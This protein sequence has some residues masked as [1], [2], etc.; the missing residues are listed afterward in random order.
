M[1]IKIVKICI[2]PTMF[3]KYKG[4]Y[5][6]SF[7]FNEAKEL[8]K[9]GFEIHVVTPHNSGI[10]FEEIMEGVH[11]HRFKWLEPQEFKALLH[12]KGIKDNLRLLTYLISL[13]FNLIWIVKKYDVDI[14]HAHSV[15]PT[16]LV[17][18]IVAKIV[19]KPVFITA[20]GMDITN[21][22]NHYFFKKLLVFSLIN[23]NKAI[24]VS[25]YLAKIIR[26][27]GTN[28]KNIAILRNAVNINIF[29]PLKNKSLRKYYKIKD[30]D[31]LILF[32]GY[33][34]S[35]KGIFEL[36]NAF[37]EI[38]KYNKNLKLMI[39]G[40]G[41]KENDLKILTK[42][43]VIEKFVLFTGKISAAEIHKYFQSADIF[44]LPSYTDAGGPPLVVIEAMASGLPVIG[45]NVGGIPE[46]IKDGINGFI[47]PP[48]NVDELTKKLDI[49]VDNKELRQK[50]GI[51][52][53]ETV[54]DEFNIDKKIDELVKLYHNE[55]N[56]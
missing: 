7:V 23:C 40:T 36:V 38:V 14:I 32:V 43:L 48:K 28:P 50:F 24:A 2:V 42:K 12:F 35:F 27:L 53:L 13:F 54:D 44:V 25:E 46:G 55:L 5:Y 11:V 21:F 22:E 15:I 31:K 3:P 6:G 30:E 19:R 51:K 39:V 1:G 41:P 29:R 4:D 47:I 49:L 45:T 9:K 10:P 52:S 26:S 18:V 56:F 37:F 16:G 8:V 17:G 34:D 33:L 20:H